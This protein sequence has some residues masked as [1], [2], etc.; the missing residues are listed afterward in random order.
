MLGTRGTELDMAT[1]QVLPPSELVRTIPSDF[2]VQAGGS[3][4]CR[5]SFARGRHVRGAVATRG[6]VVV[7]PRVAMS[8]RPPQREFAGPNQQLP[9]RANGTGVWH[10]GV[11]NTRAEHGDIGMIKA[12]RAAQHL[13]NRGTHMRLEKERTHHSS[14]YET[15]YQNVLLV[16][17]VNA[18]PVVIASSIEHGDP[19]PIHEGDDHPLLCGGKPHGV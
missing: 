5:E 10:P 19:R 3:V 13:S 1:H 16:E 14:V 8:A 4:E 7:F 9:V 17:R 15:R 6:R 11:E 2:C 12:C 18:V